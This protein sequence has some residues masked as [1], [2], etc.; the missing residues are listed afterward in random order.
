MKKALVSLCEEVLAF[1]SS[2]KWLENLE[3]LVDIIL[4]TVFGIVIATL[5]LFGI[6]VPN[7]I[8][9]VVYCKLFLLLFYLISLKLQKK[10]QESEFDITTIS[11]LFGMIEISIFIALR[12]LFLKKAV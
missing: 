10:G 1:S 8:E 12:K 7:V 4:P 11:V 3:V 5:Y 6:N 9:I 2:K